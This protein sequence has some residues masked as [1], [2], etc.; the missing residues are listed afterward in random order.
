MPSICKRTY[1]ILGCIFTGV[2]LS[3]SLLPNLSLAQIPPAPSS[4]SKPSAQP[5]DAA[6]FLKR[7]LEHYDAKSY[8]EAF[9]DFSQVIRLDPNNFRGYFY[10]SLMYEALNNPDAAL[11]DIQQAIFLNPKSPQAYAVRASLT[12]QSNPQAAMADFERSLQLDNTLATTYTVRSQLKEQLGDR[13]GALADLQQAAKL[14]HAQNLSSL[15]TL[16]TRDIQRLQLATTSA[17]VGTAPPTSSKSED[18]SQATPLPAGRYRVVGLG[19]RIG[20]NFYWGMTWNEFMTAVQNR[21]APQNRKGLTGLISPARLVAIDGKPEDG[22][23]L[24]SYGFNGGYNVFPWCDRKNC[25]RIRIRFEFKNQR[26]ARIVILRGFPLG[27]WLPIIDYYQK[28]LGLKLSPEINIEKGSE[29]TYNWTYSY[30]QG[31]LQSPQGDGQTL[32]RYY[33]HLR[34][35]SYVYVQ[36]GK[37]AYE[38]RYGRNLL[39]LLPPYDTNAPLVKSND[40]DDFQQT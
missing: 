8:Q 7:G 36:T 19:D 38:R 18:R 2:T 23:A 13:A 10:R 37:P 30:Q 9:N 17:S 1:P 35:E 40:I 33:L 31:L 21:P 25:S 32:F 39:E 34:I 22:Y 16:I 5:Q 15:L 28:Q 4:L 27:S 6:G 14:A 11:K 3:V 20:E 24:T 12:R 29:Q 26:L